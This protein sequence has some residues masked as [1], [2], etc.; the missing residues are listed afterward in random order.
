M[1]KHRIDEA[2]QAATGNL[3]SLDRYILQ[4]KMDTPGELASLARDLVDKENVTRIEQA[5]KA[6][7]LALA[8]EIWLVF[9]GLESSDV[10]RQLL[11]KLLPLTDITGITMENARHPV[12]TTIDAWCKNK[13]TGMHI[14]IVDV[15]LA[16]VQK[17][18]D[19]LFG[20]RKPLP[21]QHQTTDHKPITY[22]K[23]VPREKKSPS[24]RIPLEKIADIHVIDGTSQIAYLTG[25]KQKIEDELKGGHADAERQALLQR[26]LETVS[27]QIETTCD[28]SSKNDLGCGQ[29]NK[30][31]TPFGSITWTQAVL[32]LCIHVTQHDSLATRYTVYS[33]AI[34]VGSCDTAL[35]RRI[36]TDIILFFKDYPPM[37]DAL[38]RAGNRSVDTATDIIS[39]LSRME[40]DTVGAFLST[41]ARVVH[42]NYFFKIF[43]LKFLKDEETSLW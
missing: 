27:R 8:P 36:F 34:M 41:K 14:E 6:N 43:T 22:E 11:K 18:M 3:I 4:G 17:S 23:K 26:L 12:V 30:K 35:K 25:K 20:K 21:K 31:V 7:A 39:I 42:L 15:L 29:D 24:T 10:I 9:Q 1:L 19:L 33:M 38:F 13:A 28:P 5:C 16:L 2:I 37:V 32:A 40:G